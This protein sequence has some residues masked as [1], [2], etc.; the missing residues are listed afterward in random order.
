MKNKIKWL[1]IYLSMILSILTGCT[2]TNNQFMIAN[3][4]VLNLEIGEVLQ[5]EVINEINPNGDLIWQSSNDCVIITEDGIITCI[6]PGSSTIT[7]TFDNYIDEIIINVV[8][9]EITVK[10]MLKV[11]SLEVG[12]SIK[13]T[14]SVQPLNYQNEVIYELISGNDCA[15][16]EEDMLTAVSPGIIRIVARVKDIVSTPF[17]IEILTNEVSNDPYENITYEEFYANYTKACSYSDALYRS[18]HGF[19]S[20][21][22]SK[23][24]QEPNVALN[25]P[26]SE[27][28]LYRNSDAIYSADGNTYYIVS[29]TGEIVNQI[30]RGGAY[31][32]LEEVAAYVLA[33]GDVPANYIS[34]KSGSPLRSIWGEYLRL[35]HSAFSGD[36]SRYPYEPELPNISGCGGD[37][38][39]YEIDLGTTGTDCDPNYEVAEYNNGSYITR[40]AARIVYTRYDKNGDHIIDINEK[41]VFYTY[42]HYN[43]FQEYL[44]YEGGWGKMFGNI[45]GGGSLSSKSDYNPSPYVSTYLVSFKSLSLNSLIN[46]KYNYQMSINDLIC[47]KYCR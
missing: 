14:A 9:T 13:I 7:V 5:L 31:V 45:T 28:I 43:D 33:F 6:K 35:N 24:S 3:G 8:Q 36:I 11:S 25:Q 26:Q 38:E 12:E 44:N 34:N 40:G 37:L 4:E 41:Y 10:I 20:G 17:L 19:M 46:V 15:F 2:L 42:N 29:A 30:Y 1:M 39:Y 47:S 16:I 32:T 21:D 18:E 27:G 22:I 23:Q